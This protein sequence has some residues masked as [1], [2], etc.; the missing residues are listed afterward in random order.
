VEILFLAFIFV[1][2]L[3][4]SSHVHIFI[5]NGGRLDFQFFNKKAYFVR[6]NKKCKYCN[7]KRRNCE[8]NFN[9]E[10]NKCVL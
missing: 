3:I 2:L 10:Y 8:I 9:S 1:A 6:K 7:L 5:C 4:F